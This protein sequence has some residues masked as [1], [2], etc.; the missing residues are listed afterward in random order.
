NQATNHAPYRFIE[1]PARVHGNIM[2]VGD[3]DQSIS[4]WR[5]ADIRN[6]LDFEK[7]FPDARIVRLE[8]NYRSTGR[9]LEAANRV[10]AQNARR[11]GKTLRPMTGPGERI[12][13]VE[14][15]DEQ[16]EAEWIASEIES[17][18][19]ENPER[20]LRDFVV[21]YRTNAQSRALEEALR[22][23]DLPY[24]IVGGTRFYERREIM[25]V[26]AYLRLISNR[27]DAG[28][29]DRIVN[30]PRRGIGDLSKARLMEWAAERGLAPLD[31]AARAKECELLGSAGASALVSF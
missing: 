19:A 23:H 9:I 17:R 11:K 6:I 7:D 21:L 1:L 15:L 4:G 24:Q 29:F 12:T 16:D 30:Y 2:A 13:R 25:D 10:I 28:A 14:A 3:D 27:R 8:R 20:S 5:G 22:R 26:L 31:A 18:L